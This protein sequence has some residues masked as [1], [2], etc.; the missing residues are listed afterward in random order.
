MREQKQYPLLNMV[1][2]DNNSQQT[3][4]SNHLIS[5]KTQKT[6]PNEFFIEQSLVL[7]KIQIQGYSIYMLC[8]EISRCV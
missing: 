1:E 4:P 6:D 3:Q 7:K 8:L 2:V 5:L